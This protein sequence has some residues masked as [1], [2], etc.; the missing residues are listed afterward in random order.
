MGATPKEEIMAVTEEKTPRTK[1]GATPSSTT[2]FL[3]SAT[4]GDAMHRGVLSCPFETPLATVARMMAAHHVHCVVGLGDVTE[5]DTRLWG[6]VS[7]RD[8]LATVATGEIARQTAGGSAATQVLTVGAHES[9]RRAAELMNDKGLT[10]VIV[11]EPGT[12]RPVGVLSTLDIAAVVGGVARREAA[13]GAGATRVRGVMTTPAISVPPEMP[14]K[15]VAAILVEHRISGVPVARNEEVVGVISEADIVAGEGVS[16][17]TDRARLLAWLMGGDSEALT[18]RLVAR[19]AGEAMSAPAITI[20]SWQSAGAAAATMT[21]HGV[22]RLPVLKNG[23]LVGIV[24]RSDL[25]RAFARS[26]AELERDI[27]EN[28]ISRELWLSPTEITVE[29]RGGEVTLVGTVDREV[30]VDALVHQ[31]GRVP[32]VVSVV[33][34]L[35]VRGADGVRRRRF[36]RLSRR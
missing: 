20:D 1:A 34:T 31:V 29:V 32:G 24:S 25:V 14:L 36:R 28:V 27:R 8:I 9:L 12:D 6:V 33:P 3:D 13:Q 16:A 2:L 21:K 15:D 35:T 18:S 23:V 7:D 10:H 26:D 22:K 11:V 17:P 5:D 4:V 19:T 30:D